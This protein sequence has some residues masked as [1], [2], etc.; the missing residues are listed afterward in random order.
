MIADITEAIKGISN[1]KILLFADDLVCICNAKTL[2]E[3]KLLA[4]EV[5]ERFVQ[6]FNERGIKMSFPKTNFLV[7]GSVSP[8]L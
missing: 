1:V 6:Y 7:F 5:C 2:A 3:V 4:R 8:I